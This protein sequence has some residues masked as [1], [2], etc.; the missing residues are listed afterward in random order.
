M[1]NVV[2]MGTAD[3]AA[4]VLERLAAA[5]GV[6]VVGVVSQ[7]DRPAGRN[8]VLTPSAVSEVAKRLGLPL[9]TPERIA[10]PDSVAWLRSLAPDA[11]V[12]FA[13]GQFLPR[14]VRELPR[15]GSINIHP[16]RLPAL[17]GAAPIPWAIANGETSTAVSIIRMEKEMDAG[18]VLACRDLDID[19]DDT[20]ASLGPRAADLGADLVLE[21]L[22]A[23]AEGT[24]RATPQDASA[25]THARKLEKSD[26]RLDWT[27]P[28]SVLRNRIRAFDPWPGAVF[29]VA[30]APADLIKVW[31]ARVEEGSGAPGTILSIDREGPLLA[32][33]R[34]AL[35]LLDVQAPGKRRMSA[36]EAARGAG[37]C[38]GTVFG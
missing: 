6:R 35:R 26:A 3:I 21:T 2:Y 19:P 4:P 5:S 14:S 12:V 16:S 8:R 29:N 15:L 33:G 22:R 1:I 23:M 27:Q 10:D 18:D 17:R 30:D 11:A 36:A 37:W 34:D 13:F 28:A 31:R 20:T 9:L 38:P 7:P 24:V 32:C 25:A